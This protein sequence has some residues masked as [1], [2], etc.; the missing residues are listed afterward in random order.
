MFELENSQQK[1]IVALSS[2]ILVF[3]LYSLYNLSLELFN[4]WQFLGFAHNPKVSLQI[5]TY[6][7]VCAVVVHLAARSFIDHRE[8]KHRSIHDGSTGLGNEKKLIAD[9][10]AEKKAGNI[11]TKATLFKVYI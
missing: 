1:R 9:L 8:L 4:G 10:E 5:I 3:M 2:A 6:I 7:L 11:E